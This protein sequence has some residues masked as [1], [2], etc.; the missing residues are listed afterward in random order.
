MGSGFRELGD[1]LISHSRDSGQAVEIHVFMSHTHWDHIQGWPFFIPAYRPN[2]NIHF[3]SVHPN[4]KE[5]LEQQQDFRFFPV[6]FEFMASKKHFHTLE[7]NSTLVL[8]DVL[9]KNTELNHPGKSY[10]YRV[11]YEGKSFVY[12]SD[13]E[14]NNLPNSRIKTY[15]DFYRD[16]DVLVFDAPYSFTEEIEKINWG[17]SSAL[18]GIDIAVKAKVKKIVLFH[19]APENDDDAVFRLLDTAINYKVQNYPRS[20]LEVVLARERMTI[21][22]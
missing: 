6:A 4:F 21:P 10:C 13:G 9:I 8:N 3:Y 12:T 18:V 15:I 7:V 16:A 14:Y 11:E 22:L 17:H 19:H 1:R 5:R 2:S 20:N